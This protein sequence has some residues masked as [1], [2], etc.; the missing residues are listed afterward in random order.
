MNV[1]SRRKVKIHR[2]DNGGSYRFYET[3]G[4]DLVKLHRN[5]GVT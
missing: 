5:G 4:W 1:L 3:I 2:Y